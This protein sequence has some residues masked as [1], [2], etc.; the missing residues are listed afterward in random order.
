[1]LK[2]R[3]NATRQ[4]STT[5]LRIA[6]EPPLFFEVRTYIGADLNGK[7]A[8]WEQAGSSNAGTAAGLIAECFVAVSQDGQSYPLT[9]QAD[10]LA[11]RDTIEEAA[12]GQGD[13]YLCAILEGFIREHYSFFR[14][15]ERSASATSSPVSENGKAPELSA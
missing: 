5:D 12:P 7:M 9:T 10:V 8:D 2:L 3:I 6:W 4:I 11:L 1:M 15:G 14:R 13:M